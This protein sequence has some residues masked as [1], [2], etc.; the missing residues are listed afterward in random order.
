MKT[1]RPTTISLFHMHAAFSTQ[2]LEG[3]D[4]T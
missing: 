2:M 3:A 4:A 1:D